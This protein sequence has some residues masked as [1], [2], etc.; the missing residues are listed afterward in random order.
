MLGYI[1]RLGLTVLSWLLRGKPRVDLLDPETVVTTS[2][3]C[4]PWD[5]DTNL[6]MN[7]SRY[8]Y[9]A[10]FARVAF[11]LAGGL[12]AV[13]RT[14][15]VP[16]VGSSL[17]SFRRSIQPFQRYDIRTRLVALDGRNVYIENLFVDTA[18]RAMMQLV[19]RWVL[20]SPSKGARGRAEATEWFTRAG[21][22]P[23]AVA[24]FEERTRGLAKT[25]EQ[26]TRHVPYEADK[27]K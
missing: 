10:D 6:H 5:L 17:A 1:I 26:A 11:Y 13:P 12:S 22:A 25:L 15:I 27:T 4:L 19:V 7:N 16:V 9:H 3:L 20:L 21:Y 24:A 14:E 23:E 2:H 18:G 8:S